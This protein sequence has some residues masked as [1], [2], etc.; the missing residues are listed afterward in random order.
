MQGNL[1]SVLRKLYYAK[2]NMSEKLNKHH[3]ALYHY[4]AG[5]YIYISKYLNTKLKHVKVHVFLFSN[6]H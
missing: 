5:L 3:M 4:I 6:S 2:S 1:N